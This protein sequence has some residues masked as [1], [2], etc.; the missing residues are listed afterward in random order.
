MEL[1]PQGGLE[2]DSLTPPVRQARDEGQEDRRTGD[3]RVPG[4]WGLG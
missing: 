1:G 3:A 4:P 2:E